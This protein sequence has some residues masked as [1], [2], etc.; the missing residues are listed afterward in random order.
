M[1]GP[2]L[3][4]SALTKLPDFIKSFLSRHQL[5]MED[6]DVVIPHQ[7]SASAIH[8]IR[9]RLGIPKCKL[10]EL[11]EYFGNCLSASIPMGLHFGLEPNEYKTPSIMK[12]D[13]V[14]VIG[15]GAGLTLG[16]CLLE[17]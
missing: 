16:T 17:F 4:K 12:G 13:K 3:F 14:L 7:A 15:T 9:R 5:L 8:L 6:I 1:K 11:V 10:V 2:E